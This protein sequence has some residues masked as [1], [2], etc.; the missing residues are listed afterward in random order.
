MS[1][2]T[3]ASRLGERLELTAEQPPYENDPSPAWRARAAGQGLSCE[4]VCLEASWQ[5][6][7]LADW[8]ADLAASAYSTWEG[9]RTWVSSDSQLSLAILHESTNT[10]ILETRLEN[11][12]PPVWI[13]E[14]SIEMDPGALQQAASDASAAVAGPL[15]G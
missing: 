14:L 11:G 9:K 3:F 4:L 15:G 10:V 1:I 13:V 12:A 6:Q 8:L 2:V 7:G 5:E